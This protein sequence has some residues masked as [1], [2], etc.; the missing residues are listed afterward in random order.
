[1]AAKILLLEDDLR[2]L[3]HYKRAIEDVFGDRVDVYAVEAVE[4]AHVLLNEHGYNFALLIADLV[5]DGERVGLKLAGQVSTWMPVIAISTFSPEGMDEDTS[6]LGR[7]VFLDKNID[8]SE[9]RKQLTEEI[10]KAIEA[11]SQSNLGL[12]RHR[13]SI[14]AVHFPLP[15]V[16][17]A[18]VPRIDVRNTDL[19]AIGFGVRHWQ[20]AV[21]RNRGRITT[22]HGQTMLC[23]FLDEGSPNSSDQN[24]IQA[25]L[26]VCQATKGD[27]RPGFERCPFSVACVPGTLV[28]G[29]FGIAPPGIPAIVGRTSDIATQLTRS[30]KSREIATVES[31]LSP[32]CRAWFQKLAGQQRIENQMFKSVAGNVEVSFL[33]R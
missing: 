19:V 24:A 17:L 14:L 2:L 8:A 21:E 1:M 12:Q 3:A 32:D 31:W 9:F 6:P 22:I 10:G 18:D 30:A 33:R 23:V 16:R 13:G 15:Q 26:D 7:M 20:S 29:T 27:Y 25:F 4:E 28:S 5:K 11:Q